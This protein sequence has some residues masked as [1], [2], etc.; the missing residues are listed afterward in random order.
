MLPYD[1]ST[2]KPAN[3]QLARSLVCLA[4]R[5]FFNSLLSWT[6]QHEDARSDD[7]SWF[8]L[9]RSQEFESG[10]SRVNS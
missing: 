1:Q 7:D 8:D 9:G 3:D 10:Q 6:P 4:G 5:T 2:T